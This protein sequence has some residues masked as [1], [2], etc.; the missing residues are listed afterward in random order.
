MQIGAL[1]LKK[2][3]DGKSYFSGVVEYPGVNLHVAIFKNEKKEKESQPDYQIIWSPPKDA[4]LPAQ[5]HGV[6]D[7]GI[8]F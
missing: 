2:T 6:D 8:P 3:K 5:E 1:W 4:K 7:D